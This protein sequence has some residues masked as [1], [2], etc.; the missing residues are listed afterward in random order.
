MT[1]DLLTF[2]TPAE[3]T[4]AGCKFDGLEEC[5]CHLNLKKALTA[6]AQARQRNATLEE[7]FAM[8]EQSEQ[9]AQQ[10]L[11]QAREDLKRYGVHDMDCDCLILGTLTPSGNCTC[12]LKAILAGGADAKQ[13]QS[14]TAGGSA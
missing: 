1:P 4:M 14:P 9:R 3:Q 11:Q 10:H 2:L 8:A 7:S 6:L 13:A 12:G 5:C